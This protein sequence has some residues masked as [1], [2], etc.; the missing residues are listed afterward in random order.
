MPE[1]DVKSL[2]LET[3]AAYFARF[4]FHKTTMNEIARHMH[5]AKGGIYYYFESKEALFNEVL[6]RELNNI[7]LE[8]TRIIAISE[9]SL[10]TLKKY[11]L[12]RLKLVKDVFTYRETLKAEFFEKYNFTKEV[13]NDFT[14][15][16]RKQ[17]TLILKKGRDEGFVKVPNI[18]TTVNSIL[19]ILSGIEIPAFVQGQ[20]DKYENTIEEIT[21]MIVNSLRI[22]KTA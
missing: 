19:M 8:L 10:T 14:E 20:Y 4:G 11:I 13:R 7:K 17:L 16:E 15:F 2:I 21:D 18:H 22:N 5:K 12:T 1:G 6:K 9:D 3:A